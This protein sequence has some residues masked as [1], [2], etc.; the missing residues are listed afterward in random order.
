MPGI[1]SGLPP[2]AKVVPL[3]N[4]LI[5]YE[6]TLSVDVLGKLCD[7]IAKGKKALEPSNTGTNFCPSMSKLNF[8]PFQGIC[9][10]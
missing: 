10:K 5:I 9:V 4:K 8:K 3:M 2:F 6:D 1:S 7:V